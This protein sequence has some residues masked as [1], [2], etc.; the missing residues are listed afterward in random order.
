MADCFNDW[1]RSNIYLK[2]LL[3]HKHRLLADEHIAKLS[4]ETRELLNRFSEDR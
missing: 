4:D 1:R 3:L 2:L